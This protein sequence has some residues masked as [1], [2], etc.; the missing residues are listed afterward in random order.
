MRSKHAVIALAIVASGIAVAP[1]ALAAQGGGSP[2]I[3][4]C[5]SKGTVLEYKP[6][7]YILTCADANASLTKLTWQQWNAGTAKGAGTFVSNTC[8]P[9]CAAGTFVESAA[10]VSLTRPRKVEGE[11]A[12]TRIT[13]TTK[14]DGKVTK[15]TYDAPSMIK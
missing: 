12:F 3:V 2:K 7:S 13:V 5:T 15:V 10:M 6:T 8:E 9:T 14:T 1:A 4:A 11:K